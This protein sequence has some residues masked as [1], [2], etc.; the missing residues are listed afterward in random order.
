M[1]MEISKEVAQ[2]KCDF[3]LQYKNFYYVSRLLCKSFIS[4]Q[5]EIYSSIF[6]IKYDKC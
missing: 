4:V 3:F 5:E 6:C 2:L 1:T